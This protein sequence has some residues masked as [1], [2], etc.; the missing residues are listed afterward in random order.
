MNESPY[1]SWP[2]VYA[3]KLMDASE[4]AALV[5]PGDT[6]VIPIGSIT[7]ALVEAI[8]ERRDELS[9][10]NVLSCAPFLDPGWYEPGHPAFT[11]HVEIFNT[12]IARPSMNRGETGFVTIPFSRRF[13]AEDERGGGRYLIDVVLVGV[14]P[15]DRFGYC[16]FGT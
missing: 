13:K 1:A 10:V 9:G 16:S 12:S 6:I 4:A 2:E 7:P 15:P 14:S 11:M 5:H 3:S 8:W